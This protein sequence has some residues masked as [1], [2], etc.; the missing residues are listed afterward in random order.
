MTLK[1]FNNSNPSEVSEAN[2]ANSEVLFLKIQVEAKDFL[3]K[4]LVN[5]TEF[6]KRPV[7]SLIA[8]LKRWKDTSSTWI[9]F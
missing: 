2:Q 8:V 3:I 9:N 4:D 6:L 7:S 1:V 5:F